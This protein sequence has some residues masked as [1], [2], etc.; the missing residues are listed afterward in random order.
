MGSERQA[1]I[2]SSPQDL[3]QDN[4]SIAALD[5]GEALVT[6]VFTKFAVPIKVPLFEE[7]AK[8]DRKEKV[9]VDFS[10]F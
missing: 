9:K 3:S 5:K 6:S 2:E 1:V 10:G 7:F 8:K 4:R